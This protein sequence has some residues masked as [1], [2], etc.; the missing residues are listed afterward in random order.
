MKSYS[1]IL[2]C[3][4]TGGRGGFFVNVPEIES[5]RGGKV[6]GESLFRD[7]GGRSGGLIEAPLGGRLRGECSGLCCRGLLQHEN[8][9]TLLLLLL[10]PLRS[11]FFTSVSLMLP[12]TTYPL[13]LLICTSVC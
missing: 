5:L 13:V 2:T 10:L 12:F 7:F 1:Y 3:D 8:A 4:G 11:K 6:G 9:T